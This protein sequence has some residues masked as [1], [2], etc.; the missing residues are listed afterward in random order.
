MGPPGSD[1]HITSDALATLN[2][3][4]CINTGEILRKEIVANT[5]HGQAIQ[6][7]QDREEYGKLTF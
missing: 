4:E 2:G 7:A 6:A 5:A 3:W 1:R